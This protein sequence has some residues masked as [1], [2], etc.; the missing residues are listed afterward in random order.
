M[1]LI[2]KISTLVVLSS[3]SSFALAASA[4]LPTNAQVEFTGK[5]IDASCSIDNDIT[6]GTNAIVLP[7]LPISAVTSD[8]TAVGVTDFTVT[9]S[10][11][12]TSNKEVVLTNFTDLVTTGNA[13]KNLKN[14]A[15]GTPAT[16]VSVQVQF[17]TNTA[18]ATA[19][20]ANYTAIVFDGS[21][22]TPLATNV[23]NG[24]ITEKLYFK[25]GYVRTDIGTAPTG[26]DVK[27]GFTVK[28]AYK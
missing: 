18:G 5:I 15:T 9:V 3:I 20:P 17:S 4:D 10:G 13:E 26:G 7:T 25:A 8:T 23:Q 22:T 24:P 28:V 1:K 27:A 16:G 2:K 11:C 14:S 21:Q 6:T 12:G 19:V